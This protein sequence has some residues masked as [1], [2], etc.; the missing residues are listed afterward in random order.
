MSQT[1]TG[2]GTTQFIERTAEISSKNRI[3]TKQ[4]DR[5]AFDTDKTLIVEV[6]QA[7]EGVKEQVDF[8][9]S[10]S[11]DGEFHIPAEYMDELDLSVGDEVTYRI[12]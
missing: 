7:S 8:L 2:S 11:S 12:F 6:S 4:D 9:T 10:F 3:Y 5:E 1:E